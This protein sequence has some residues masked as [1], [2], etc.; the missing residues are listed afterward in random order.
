MNPNFDKFQT[1]EDRVAK[2]AKEISEMCEVDQSMRKRD[3][4]GEE[5]AWDD[6]FDINNTKKMKRIVEEIGWPTISK[7][8]ESAS[9]DAW[10]LVQHSDHDVGFQIQCLEL[11]KSAPNG[12]VSKEN[13]AFL[14]DRV[15]VNQG[16]G[17]LYGTQ[18]F[19]KDGQHIPQ[20]IED[21]ENVDVRR[22]SMG[23]G[24]L[25]ERIAEMYE[26]YPFT[27]P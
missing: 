26:K 5:D 18:F 4:E 21:E 12:D 24:T 3:L 27:K 9:Y 25:A 16:R 17:Q 22:A 15:R 7:V 8:G 10:L 1:P 14:E 19:Q 13:I 2:I 6:S 11:M 20:P 23:M